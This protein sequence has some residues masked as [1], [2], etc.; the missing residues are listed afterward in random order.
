MLAKG[1]TLTWNAIA[2]AKINNIGGVELTATKEDTTTHDD[3]TD[4]Y[5]THVVS[6]KEASDI[7]V[8]GYCDPTDTT[9]QLA[10]LGD[11]HSGT[12]RE[13]IMT[14]TDGSTWTFT[15]DITAIKIGDAPIEG[16]IPFSATLSPTGKPVFAAAV[17]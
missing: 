15:A 4:G 12:Q 3:A 13:A 9:G 6:W 16:N 1:T 8:E 11:F 17:A 7:S 10:M 14:F 2:V 5:K